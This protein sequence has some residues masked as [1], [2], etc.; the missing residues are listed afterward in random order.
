[1][2]LLSGIIGNST[3]LIII[4]LFSVPSKAQ[5]WE[6]ITRELY[7]HLEPDS[8]Y[9]SD[10]LFRKTGSFLLHPFTGDLY[11]AVNGQNPL[12]LSQD[13][14]EEWIPL[15]DAY[16]EGRTFGGFSAGIFPREGLKYFF[17]IV[18]HKNQQVRG[19]VL[20]PD[21]QVFSVI[22]KP[23]SHH[24]GWSWGMP[25][26]NNPQVILGKEHHAWT[27]LWLSKDGGESWEKLDFESRNPGVVT[28][29]VFLAGNADG[30]YRS[31]DQGKT[32]NKVSPYVI[33]G[34][35]PVMHAEAVYWTTKKGLAKS[36]DQGKTWTLV[37]SPLPG[38]LYGPYFG[39][40]Q[41]SMMV[42]AEDGFFILRD[43]SDLWQKVAPPFVIPEAA[44]EGAYNIRFSTNSYGWDQKR[45]L[46]YAAGLGADVYKL[47]IE[48]VE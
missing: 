46:L 16:T 19:L 34:K 42:V 18:M 10:P 38:S 20:G 7:H 39:I 28:D 13:Q 37:G 44:Y 2:N 14:G 9:A 33:T 17:T 36:P 45:N 24:D 31:I 3:W 22:K 23:A 43:G 15:P 35:T 40:D 11:L 48:A 12:Y 8:G 21:D 25:A 1:M 32:W 26:G 29:S 41:H 27:V 5:T 6:N 4:W 47:K 30:I